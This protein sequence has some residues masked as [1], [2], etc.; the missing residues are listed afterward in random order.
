LEYKLHI[1]N[2][3]KAGEKAGKELRGWDNKEKKREKRA[4]R[5]PY[6]GHSANILV[7]GGN[8]SV[9]KYI[10]TGLPVPYIGHLKTPF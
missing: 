2:R 10:K 3:D 4:C 5:V 7:R 1:P 8:A 9:G 6:V